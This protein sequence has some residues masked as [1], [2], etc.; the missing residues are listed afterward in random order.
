M[1][2][3][4][5]R[6]AQKNSSGKA[7]DGGQ[8]RH[9]RRQ[10]QAEK[11]SI[12]DIRPRQRLAP[13]AQAELLRDHRRITPDLGEGPGADDDQR[14]GDKQRQQA[15]EDEADPVEAEGDA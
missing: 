7:D 2:R 5:K 12:P 4:G 1:F 14:Q 9:R 13:E 3:P 8:E 11:Q 15:G 10:P 6:S